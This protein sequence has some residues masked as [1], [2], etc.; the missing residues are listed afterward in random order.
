[1]STDKQLFFDWVKI[2]R[3]ADVYWF[4]RPRAHHRLPLT[5]GVGTPYSL[6]P[7]EARAAH[8]LLVSLINEDRA[9]SGLPTLQF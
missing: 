3:P 2:N 7:R 4:A 9:H 8:R 5:T 1:M 6:L